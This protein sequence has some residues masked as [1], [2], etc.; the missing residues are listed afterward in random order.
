MTPIQL[1]KRKADWKRRVKAT[2]G[3][4]KLR[5]LYMHHDEEQDMPEFYQIARDIATLGI[6]GNRLLASVQ[7]MD[8]QDRVTLDI[9]YHLLLL[10]H[11]S[12]EFYELAYHLKWPLSTLPTYSCPNIVL[13]HY[14][15]GI[16]DDKEKK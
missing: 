15:E 14:P 12:Q 3:R 1:T 8:M 6:L 2:L 11:W 4:A 7:Q 10:D 13:E 9:E 16:K 5:H